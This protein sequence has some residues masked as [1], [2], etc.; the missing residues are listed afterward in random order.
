M[1]A[2]PRSLLLPDYVSQKLAEGY[3]PNRIDYMLPRHLP[4][5]KITPE[6]VDN[7]GA[8]TEN[9]IRRGGKTLGANKSPTAA[10]PGL[11]ARLQ[12]N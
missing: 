9:L 2:V 5:Q 6:I 3:A 11:L 4:F 10:L 1:H 8:Y 7:V 12:V